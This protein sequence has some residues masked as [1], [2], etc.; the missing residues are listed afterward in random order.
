VRALSNIRSSHSFITLHAVSHV[1]YPR[2]VFPFHLIV[3]TQ[4]GNQL[5]GKEVLFDCEIEVHDR[6]LPGD[7]VILDLRDFDLI[8]GMDYLSSHCAKVD[9]CQKIIYFETPL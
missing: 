5:W 4:G 2:I 3:S 6:K 1:P 7:L 9:C 8:L